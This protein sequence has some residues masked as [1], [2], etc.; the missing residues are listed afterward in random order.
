LLGLIGTV[1][2]VAAAVSW[3]VS[4][5]AVDSGAKVSHPS[6]AP[7]RAE[8]LSSPIPATGYLAAVKGLSQP[9]AVGSLPIPPTGYLEAVKG[10]STREAQHVQAISSMT[11]V[12]LLEAFG[13]NTH[14]GVALALLTPKERLDVESIMALTPAQLRAAFGTN[15]APTE[16]AQHVQAITS[17]TPQQRVAAFGTDVEAAAALARLTPSEQSHVESIMALTPAQLRAT[18]GTG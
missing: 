12:Q 3:A 7:T 14:A 15:F 10:L 16:E 11:P 6:V 4:S 18:F 1:A 5:Y 8:V 9:A 13:T 2:A 17:L